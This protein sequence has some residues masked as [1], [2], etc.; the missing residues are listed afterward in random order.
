MGPEF[1][2]AK[3]WHLFVAAG[4]TNTVEESMS[5]TVLDNFSP[6]FIAASPQ[7]LSVVH[8]FFNGDTLCFANP[9]ACFIFH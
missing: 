9:D 2:K 3:V 1:L 8:S 5:E 7:A 6:S 4:C